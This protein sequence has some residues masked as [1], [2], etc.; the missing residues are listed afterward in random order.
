MGVSFDSHFY[1][2]LIFQIKLESIASTHPHSPASGVD[3]DH[4]G[5]QY[6]SAI[7][8]QYLTHAH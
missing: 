4:D 1:I 3:F 2:A 6:L 7:K 5:F 8:A